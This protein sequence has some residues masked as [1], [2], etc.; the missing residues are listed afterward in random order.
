MVYSTVSP[1]APVQANSGKA[2]ASL[3]GTS[4]ASP[5]I[6]GYVHIH[7]IKIRAD[8]DVIRDCLYMSGYFL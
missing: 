6:A 5:Y 4:A 3:S 2:Y 7:C 1:F 8:L